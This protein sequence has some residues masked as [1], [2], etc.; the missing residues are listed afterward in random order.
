MILT[1]LLTA[2]AS[3]AT[4]TLAQLNDVFD[5]E[6]SADNIT[7]ATV[8]RWECAAPPLPF[9]GD[10]RQLELAPLEERLEAIDWHGHAHTFEQTPLYS[11]V[12]VGGLDASCNPGPLPDSIW[13]GLVPAGTYEGTSG[14]EEMIRAVRP[15][16]YLTGSPDRLDWAVWEVAEPTPLA[17]VLATPIHTRFHSHRFSGSHNLNHDGVRLYEVRDLEAY[18]ATGRNTLRD[19][20][21][22]KRG[23]IRNCHEKYA[24]G[25]TCQ[26]PEAEIGV[27]EEQLA[28]LEAKYAAQQ[29]E[30]AAEQAE[31]AEQADEAE[32]DAS[33]EEGP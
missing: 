22:M 8:G 17:E 10:P 14:M 31:Q 7:F 19:R 15:T 11:V 9:E 2:S 4:P 30:K 20:I 33:I 12:L 28:E 1:M 29:A 27:E 21:E 26:V 5:A 16:A 13:S 6:R 25:E 18:V 24:A 32:P 3:A 23:F